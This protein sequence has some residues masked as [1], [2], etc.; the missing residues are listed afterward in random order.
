MKQRITIEQWDELSDKEKDILYD[1]YGECVSECGWYHLNIGQLIEFLGEDLDEIIRY[2]DNR[3]KGSKKWCVACE[4]FY[5]FGKGAE[6][7]FD[8]NELID[9]L[10][11]ATKH[12]LKV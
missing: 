7:L 8:A 10:W 12:K 5:R 6:Q 11:E 4:K 2:K 9:A 1:F 3:I